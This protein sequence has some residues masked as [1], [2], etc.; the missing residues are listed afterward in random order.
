MFSTNLFLA[1]DAYDKMKKE[2]RYQT[3][4]TYQGLNINQ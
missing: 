4:S 2:Q 3:R 1:E